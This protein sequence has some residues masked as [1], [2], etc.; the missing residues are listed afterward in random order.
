MK[1]LILA[2]L[3]VFQFCIAQNTEI[4][5]KRSEV[6]LNNLF[7]HDF[8][9]A[10]EHFD[11]TMNEKFPPSKIKQ[12]WGQLEA[13]L[14]EPVAYAKPD[15]S[16]FRGMKLVQY[17]LSFKLGKI[18]AKLFFNNENKIAGFFVQPVNQNFNYSPPEYIDSTKFEEMDFVFGEEDY[19][20]PG[21]L[22][23][24]LEKEN[25]PVVVLVHGS[26]A[27]NR[28][29]Q[30]GPNR[31]FQDLAWGLAS[32][33]IGVFR[34]DK[35]TKTHALK[36]LEK[37]EEI[38][39]Y[40]ETVKDAIEAGKFLDTLGLTNDSGIFYLGHSQGGYVIPR[41]DERTEIFK[42]Y[43]SMAGLALPFDE[44]ILR[45]TTYLFNL[46]NKLTEVEKNRLIEIKE[47]IKNLQNINEKKYTSEELL[48]GFGYEY[49]KDIQNYP[50]K[51][52][53]NQIRKPILVM[54]AEKDYQV[55]ADD[56]KVWKNQLSDNKNAEF[57]SFK[58]LNHLFMVSKGEKSTAKE[59]FE[60]GN[61]EKSVI[62][63]ISK[64]IKTNN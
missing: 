64:W 2:G 14:G 58:G 9:S 25:Y 32:R 1:Y 38:T 45:Q 18:R 11:S 43:I 29:E 24:P 51:K 13:S 17:E 50:M 35:R 8:Q 48:L 4:M 55:I 41:V 36:I 40:D 49:W 39:I 7:D 46:D 26:G 3:L 27:H 6:Y 5:E 44:T 59:Y 33:G 60:Q 47:K 20:L 19:K 54:H 63:E 62:E 42:G 31:P 34:Y 10:T 21:T 61:I 15:I 56:F 57:K 52:K 16:D 22:T 12:V 28:N 23:I 30:I 53:I 37:K